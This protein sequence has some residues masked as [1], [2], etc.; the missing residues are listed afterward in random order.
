MRNLMYRVINADGVE[1]STGSW[2]EAKAPGVK[3]LETYLENVDE[4]TDKQLEW[5]R[6]HARKVR[7]KMRMKRA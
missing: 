4:H 2:S 7:E 6:A 1:F 3:I 5:M